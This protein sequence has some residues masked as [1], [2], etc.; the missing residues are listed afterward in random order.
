VHSAF[1]TLPKG[2]KPPTELQQT[3]L[4][5]GTPK[6]EP[7]SSDNEVEEEGK[8]V[9][10]EEEVVE[11]EEEVDEKEEDVEMTTEEVKKIAAGMLFHFPCPTVGTG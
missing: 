6:Q 3:K 4:K 9:K 2:T 8:E 11:K 1:F 7:L 10:K 5:R